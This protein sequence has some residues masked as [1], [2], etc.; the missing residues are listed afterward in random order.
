MNN[1]KSIL[2]V[3][4][5]RSGST[6]LQGLLNS[7]D[8]T[9]VR[10]E[11]SDF[12][13]GLYVS[14]KRLVKTKTL[15]YAQ[16][17]EEATHSW[18]GATSIDLDLFLEN[19]RRLVKDVLVPKDMSSVCYGFKEIRYPQSQNEFEDYMDFLRE[20]FP[21]VCLLFNRRNLDDVF[22]S[23]WWRNIEDKAESRAKLVRLEK[24]FDAYQKKHPGSCFQIAYEDVVFKS[25]NLLKMYDFLGAEYSE[26]TV[27]KVLSRKHSGGNALAKNSKD[28]RFQYAGPQN[29]VECSRE[30]VVNTFP[31][32]VELGKAFSLGGVIIPRDE[33]LSVADVIAYGRDGNELATAKLGLNSP[34]FH[35]KYPDVSGSSNARFAIKNIVVKEHDEIKIVAEMNDGQRCW[36]GTFSTAV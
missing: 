15:E 19:C 26:A 30:V 22:K 33:S 4:Y 17:A 18:F 1:F 14:Y 24:K 21:D 7:I 10:G 2:I 6:L 5:G 8:G 3:T 34:S 36:L 23:G 31:D 25:Q 27:D 29:Y 16:D 20:I 9:L 35:K 12:V 28:E 11:N 32:R 13:Y